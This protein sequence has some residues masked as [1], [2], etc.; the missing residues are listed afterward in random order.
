[1]PKGTRLKDVLGDKP[2]NKHIWD[3]IFQKLMKLSTKIERYFGKKMNMDQFDY[4]WC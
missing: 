2:F 3:K 4:R 1:M